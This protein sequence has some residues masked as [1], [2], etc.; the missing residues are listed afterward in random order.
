MNELKGT[1]LQIY[2]LD[3][4]GN[5]DDGFEINN[6]IKGDIFEVPENFTDKDIFNLLKKHGFLKSYIRFEDLEFVWSDSLTEIFDA[7]TGEPFWQFWD[8][9]NDDVLWNAKNGTNV[10]NLKGERLITWN[11]GTFEFGGV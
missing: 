6:V 1:F 10:F 8:I 2:K 5:E 11:D 3:V 7:T 9:D 4:L